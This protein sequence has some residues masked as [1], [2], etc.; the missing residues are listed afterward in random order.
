MAETEEKKFYP[1][2]F[3]KNEDR[4]AKIEELKKK[5]NLQRVLQLIEKGELTDD[6]D[7]DSVASKIASLQAVE[8]LAGFQEN[9]NTQEEKLAKELQTLAGKEID[10]SKLR[11]EIQDVA[12]QEGGF[13]DKY[14]QYLTRKEDLEQEQD[15]QKKTEELALLETKYAEIK[16][17][18]EQLEKIA[19]QEVDCR[20][21]EFFASLPKETQENLIAFSQA[22]AA[23]KRLD[24]DENNIG[25][26]EVLDDLRRDGVEHK[27]MG[28]TE[29]QSFI[30][31]K[32]NATGEIKNDHRFTL[33]TEGR[34]R[35]TVLNL[36]GTGL[37]INIVNGEF[38]FLKNQ[39][40]SEKQLKTLA[41]YC[42]KNG[43]EVENYAQLKDLKVEDKGTETGNVEDRLKEELNR[44]YNTERG[45]MNT[46]ERTTQAA[47]VEPAQTANDNEDFCQFIPNQDPLTL[48]RQK[49][50]DKTKARMEL[51][52]FHDPSL[53][54]YTR[55]GNSTIISV[56]ASEE[57]MRIDGERDAKGKRV[58]SKQFSVELSHKLPPEV[59]FY[60]GNVKEFKADHARALLAGLEACGC[61]YF[62]IPP[63]TE[64][65]GKAAGGAFMEASV[66]TGMVPYLKRSEKGEG[67]DVGVPDIATVFK[68][69]SEEEEMS[70]NRK[71]EYMMRWYRELKAYNNRTDKKGE[72]IQPKDKLVLYATQFKVGATFVNFQASYFDELQAHM[73]K[74][75]NGEL[76]G[77]QK[78]D[79]VDQITATKALSKIMKEML[80]KGDDPNKPGTL[81]G[82][83][84]NPLAD[85]KEELIAT[86]EAYMKAERPKVEKNIEENVGI[87]TQND[88]QAREGKINSAIAPL[89]TAVTNELKSVCA[90]L[91][92]YGIELTP[93][94]PTAQLKYSRPRGRNEENEDDKKRR[95][96]ILGNQGNGL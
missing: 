79:E 30:P 55:I 70:G 83:L 3:K 46:P 71:A 12:Q 64:I 21:A 35:H 20:R 34:I 15:S 93:N 5:F 47:A 68:K 78:W 29:F 84:Y 53:Y 40:L 36:G 59:R 86:L 22:C 14:Q 76:E 38:S 95:R 45:Q 4:A 7:E 61:K 13:E 50:V 92:Q 33:D 44:Y 57:D 67:C 96:V 58:H 66:K 17:Q 16:K 37:D 41:E 89:K 85:N 82:K 56:Y 11:K 51:M 48:D 32:D 90:T 19:A 43:L 1:F 26:K 25:F 77:G 88:P 60:M 31:E 18:H 39:N 75:M 81:N 28:E 23:K 87:D 52:G 54:R 80:G 94:I 91:K 62:I 73:Q 74:G 24:S 9:L 8:N 10:K 65:G 49:M 27:N 69:M 2:K 42:Y 63:V 6:D 72:K